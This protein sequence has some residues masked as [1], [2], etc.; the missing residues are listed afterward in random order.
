[1]RLQQPAPF[2]PG[3]TVEVRLA[4]PD[5]SAAHAR[6]VLRLPARL[7]TDEEERAVELVFINPPDA[8]R[9]ALHQYVVDR[10]GLSGS[11]RG[12]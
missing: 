9:A 1:V 10:L 4:L 3:H 5:A 2:E 12:S 7:D 6:S 8:A 11:V